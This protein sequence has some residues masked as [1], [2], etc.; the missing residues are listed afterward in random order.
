ML[1]A[2]RADERTRLLPVVIMT[3]SEQESD[4][5]ASY[6]LGA[7]SFVRKPVDFAEFLEVAKNLDVYW[8]KLNQ[9]APPGTAE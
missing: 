3:S 8:L 2:V 7:N 6:G 5:V 1:R 9:P 4:I